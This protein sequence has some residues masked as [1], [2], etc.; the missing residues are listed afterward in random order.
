MSVQNTATVWSKKTTGNF[1]RAM[2]R[3]GLVIG[4]TF[5]AAACETTDFGRPLPPDITPVMATWLWGEHKLPASVTREGA[6]RYWEDGLNPTAPV[7]IKVGGQL[8][9]NPGLSWAQE[10]T[11]AVRPGLHLPA[12]LYLHGCGGF[13]REEPTYR[14]LFL[15]HGFAVFMPN[16]FK[17]PGRLRCGSQGKLVDRVRLRH[18]EVAHALREIRKLPWV[19]H[20]RLILAGHSEGGNTV[21][22]WD[23]PGFMAYI[24]LASACTLNDSWPATPHGVP[25]LNIVGE[26]DDR[27]PGLSCEVRRTVGGSK[28]VVIPGAGHRVANYPETKQ[29]IRAFLQDC[30]LQKR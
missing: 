29:A 4:A 5:L 3:A 13:G 16:S 23:K 30:C 27:R 19:D 12:V 17:R 14:Q 22:T 9:R 20:N 8:Q 15:D 18:E 11:Q 1:V 7:W 2:A 10:A 28:S 25:F 26:N 6:P 21:D 24:S